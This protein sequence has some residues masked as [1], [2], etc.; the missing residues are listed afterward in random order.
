MQSQRPL[1]LIVDDRPELAQAL[2]RTL[3]GLACEVVA[4]DSAETLAALLAQ[5]RPQAVILDLMMPGRDGYEALPLIAAHDRAMP[6][7]LVSGHGQSWLRMGETLGRAHGLVALQTAAKPVRREELVA[8]VSVVVDT[9]AFAR[10][11]PNRQ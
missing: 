3:S 5:T 6:V 2:H 1:I 9:F 11:E 10:S 7:L 8:F 4:A